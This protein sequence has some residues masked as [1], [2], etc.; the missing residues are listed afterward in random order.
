MSLVVGAYCWAELVVTG[1]SSL[2]LC[3]CNPA[4][5][6]MSPD[7]CFLHLLEGMDW[8]PDCHQWDNDARHNNP[9]SG[10]SAKDM[11]KVHL[12]HPIGAL[13]FLIEHVPYNHHFNLQTIL[14]PPPPLRKPA[15]TITQRRGKNKFKMK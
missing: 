3:V 2:G 7:S 14:V 5:G 13:E 11:T 4:D 12:C 6:G 1:Y 8:G 10:G 9:S 15:G